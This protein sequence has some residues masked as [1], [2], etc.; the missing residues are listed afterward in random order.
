MPLELYVGQ[1]VFNPSSVQP[2]AAALVSEPVPVPV[3]ESRFALQ[4]STP[5]LL[6]PTPLRLHQGIGKLS[7]E[8]KGGRFVSHMPCGVFGFSG[9][10]S[11]VTLTV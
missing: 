8:P 9:R 1:S 7:K 11:P 4:A 6:L 5:G 3:I 2:E 10:L